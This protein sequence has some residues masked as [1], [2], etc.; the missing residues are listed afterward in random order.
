MAA[1]TLDLYRSVLRDKGKLIRAV[2]P[3]HKRDQARPAINED[4][5][6]PQQALRTS[7]D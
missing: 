6:L 2:T 3:L 1:Q 7:R 4:A 5:H